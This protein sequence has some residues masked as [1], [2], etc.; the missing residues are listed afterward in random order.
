[1]SDSIVEQEI[2]EESS[3]FAKTI[4]TGTDESVRTDDV[5]TPLKKDRLKCLN[6]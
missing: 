1:L 5:P 6:N 3:A 4:S 2:C